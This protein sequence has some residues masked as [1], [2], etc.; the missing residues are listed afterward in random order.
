MRIAARSKP[1]V[2]RPPDQPPPSS[3]HHSPKEQPRPWA[4]P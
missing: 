2:S 4:T 3:P 1:N